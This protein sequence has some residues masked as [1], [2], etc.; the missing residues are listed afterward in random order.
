MDA[1]AERRA[2][3]T[4]PPRSG[5]ASHARAHQRP[6]TTRQQASSSQ[7]PRGPLLLSSDHP[8]EHETA[9]LPVAD[10]V[11]LTMRRQTPCFQ[12]FVK[13]AKPPSGPST[14]AAAASL[15]PSGRLRPHHQPRPCRSSCT[16]TCASMHSLPFT[17]L[18]LVTATHVLSERLAFCHVP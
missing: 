17:D 5:L 14:S 8:D 9:E 6:F 16:Y 12:A 11:E 4:G 7:A 18:R 10:P 15:S 2:A 13:R 3:S 1:S